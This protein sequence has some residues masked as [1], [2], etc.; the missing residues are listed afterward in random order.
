MAL[1]TA[2]STAASLAG[3][4]RG[5]HWSPLWWAYQDL[6][7]KLQFAISNINA[8]ISNVIVMQ[9]ALISA[10]NSGVSLSALSSLASTGTSFTSYVTLSNFTT[11]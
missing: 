4:A 9:S 3:A 2:V 1:P 11:T 7:A 5:L 6:P 8:L 10:A